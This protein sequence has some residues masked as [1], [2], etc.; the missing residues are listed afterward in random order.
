MSEFATTI[1]GF[2][3]SE[4]A[5]LPSYARFREALA[6]LVDET[7]QPLSRFLSDVRHAALSSPFGALCS[8]DERHGTA[9]PHKGSIRP[10]S[11]GIRCRY[12]CVT[13]GHYWSAI[14]QLDSV[15]WCD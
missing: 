14:H 1:R 11:G 2:G 12:R 8:A 4:M 15:T 6:D 13:C 5:A 10:E 7:G 3:H 9:W